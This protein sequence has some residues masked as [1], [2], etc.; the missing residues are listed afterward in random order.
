MDIVSS[1]PPHLM[2]QVLQHVEEP[3]TMRAVCRAWRDIFEI[4]SHMGKLCILYSSSRLF[5]MFL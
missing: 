3:S 5:R 2:I 1:L 4:G